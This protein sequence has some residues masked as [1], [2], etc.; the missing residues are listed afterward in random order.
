MVSDS[1]CVAWLWR[2][3]LFRARVKDRFLIV[4]RAEVAIENNNKMEHARAFAQAIVGD[5]L[6]VLFDEQQ[7]KAVIGVLDPPISICTYSS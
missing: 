1:M 4:G 3:T 5:E 6:A 7:L 2:K